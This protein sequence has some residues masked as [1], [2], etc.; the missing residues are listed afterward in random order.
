MEHFVT[1]EL[2][3]AQN[4]RDSKILVSSKSPDNKNEAVDINHPAFYPPTHPPV[5]LDKY[6]E[7]F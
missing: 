1:K 5:F 4:W 7:L 2:P 6:E 3:E